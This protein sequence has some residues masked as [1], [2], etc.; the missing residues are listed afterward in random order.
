[1]TKSLGIAIELIPYSESS[2]IIKALTREKAQISI[3]AKGWRKKKEPLLRFVEYD[4][5]LLE[6]KEEG[7]YTLKELCLVKDFSNYPSSATWAAAEA[8]AELISKII[9][10]ISEAVD[11]YTLLRDYLAYLQKLHHNAIL[12]FWRL[13]S[14]IF[15]MM[16]INM[17]L[18]LCDI[19]QSPSTPAALGQSGNLICMSCYQ[20]SLDT[21]EYLPLSATARQVLSLLPQIGNH[22]ENI[23]LDK[24]VIQE[25]NKVFLDYY[26]AHNKQTLKLKSLSVLSQFY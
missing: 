23:K 13:I 26:S 1:M 3:I 21:G 6:P 22:V 10:P 14:R 5:C 18:D 9:F 11:Y 17:D 2:Y 7:L 19:C 4:F 15:K 24:G 25:L 20:Q 12:I 16:G 8:G